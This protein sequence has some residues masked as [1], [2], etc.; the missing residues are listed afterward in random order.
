MKVKKKKA[1]ILKQKNGPAAYLA[2]S[3][4]VGTKR[5]FWA[6]VAG[7]AVSVEHSPKKAKETWRAWNASKWQKKTSQPKGLTNEQIEPQS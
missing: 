6:V 4:Y 5:H 2:E 3:M 1:R 7:F